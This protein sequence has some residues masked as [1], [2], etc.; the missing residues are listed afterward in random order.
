MTDRN[1]TTPTAA[2][3]T[4]F[5]Q[6]FDYFNAALFGGTLP[7]VILNFSRKA[8]TLGFF[9]PDRW[10]REGEKVTHEISL[11][12][13]YLKHRDQ[14]AVVSTLVH[15]MAH[16]WQQEFGKPS[17]RG[18]HNEEWAAKMEELGL[19]PSS[20][21]APGGARTGYR[22]SHYI[23]DGGPFARAFEKMPREYLLPWLCWE[24]QGARAKKPRQPSKVKFTCEVCGSNAWGKPD[25]KLV[26]GD[27]VQPMIAVGA[28][29]GDAQGCAA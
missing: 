14:R 27:C 11:N 5:Q 26:C 13:A 29:D 20:T 8:N 6:M 22:V 10:E 16:H 24:G 1:D 7:P 2:Q 25:L 4:A 9:A 23:I 15:E 19:M 18:Y 21:A 3:F 12:P 17:R 28:T